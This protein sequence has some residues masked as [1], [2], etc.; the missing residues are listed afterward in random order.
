M[1]MNKKTR[2]LTEEQYRKIIT[3]INE[4]FVTAAGERV[5]PNSRIAT[6]LT[7]EAN[8]GLRIS[9]ILHLTIN[10]I[11]KD[12]DRYRLDLVEQK[13]GKKREF[14]VPT[15]IYIY[16]QNYALENNINPRARLFQITERTVQRH[17][18]M[19]CDYLEYEY[20]ST[21]SFRKFFASSIYKDNGC[22]I[23][24]VRV[25]LQHS[26]VVTTQRY[27]GVQPQEIENALQKHINLL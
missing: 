14:T 25:L 19:V 8:L 21:H 7:L 5:K 4:G 20:I 15:E 22:D 11:V 23:N 16:I 27:I 9:D 24:L 2:A 13:T 26:S 6:A 12:G 18:K 1:I 10:Q 3:T 17:L